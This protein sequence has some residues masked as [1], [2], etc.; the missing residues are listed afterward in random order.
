MVLVKAK[1]NISHDVKNIL[2]SKNAF[3]EALNDKVRVRE[4]EA[5]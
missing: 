4:I 2:S 5:R 1:E 3:Y